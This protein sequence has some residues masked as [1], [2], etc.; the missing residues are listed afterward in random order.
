M[1]SAPTATSRARERGAATHNASG[2]LHA[3]PRTAAAGSRARRLTAGAATPAATR[4]H[5]LARMALETRK[6]REYMRAPDPPGAPTGVR[7]RG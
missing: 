7:A 1:F 6:T 5:A 2:A 3:A 4:T